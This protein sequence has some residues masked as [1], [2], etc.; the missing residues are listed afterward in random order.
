MAY[1]IA[2]NFTAGD[3][4]ASDQRRSARKPA[5]PSWGRALL[6]ALVESRMRAAKRELRFRQLMVDETGLVLG[7]QRDRRAV[8]PFATN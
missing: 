3:P 6:D 2:A 4:R 5:S 8:L 7:D 1:L